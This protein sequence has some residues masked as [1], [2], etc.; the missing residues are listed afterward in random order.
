[1]VAQKVNRA[2]FFC[3]NEDTILPMG[4]VPHGAGKWA[5]PGGELEEV[6]PVPGA[7]RDFLQETNV[8]LAQEVP[9]VALD[10]PDY[11]TGQEGP[12]NNLQAL[13]YGVYFYQ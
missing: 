13:Y 5:L 4:M 3:S 8:D 12:D 11:F 7:I 10:T 1:M 6:H 2:Y 9:G